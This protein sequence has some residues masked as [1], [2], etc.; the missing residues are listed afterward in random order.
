MVS[1]HFLYAG[2]ED[3][4]SGVPR[5]GCPLALTAAAAGDPQGGDGYSRGQN[6]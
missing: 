5:G 1:A 3:P 4:L 6:V 2:H